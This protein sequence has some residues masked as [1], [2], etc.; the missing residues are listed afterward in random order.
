MAMIEIHLR[1]EVNATQ[2]D[3]IRAQIKTAA[4]N[5]GLEGDVH[6]SYRHDE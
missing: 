3:N 1:G 5:L 6:I 4:G 2:A